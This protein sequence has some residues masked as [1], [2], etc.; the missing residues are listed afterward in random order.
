MKEFRK[1]SEISASDRR[2]RKK[3]GV[4]L[5]CAWIQD[6]DLDP[7]SSV[8]GRTDSKV[9]TEE[10]GGGRSGY[11]GSAARVQPPA[12]NGPIGDIPR[13]GGG[14]LLSARVRATGGS[15]TQAKRSPQLRAVR[16][17]QN[18]QRRLDHQP[19]SFQATEIPCFLFPVPPERRTDTHWS[20]QGSRQR[21]PC[22]D[23]RPDFCRLAR[24]RCTTGERCKSTRNR[25]EVRE[26]R[27]SPSSSGL[28]RACMEL[29]GSLPRSDHLRGASHPSPPVPP[30]S[31]PE[32]SSMRTTRRISRP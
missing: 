25:A 23:C 15:E 10:P 17:T 2:L 14:E 5:N 1:S 31:P 9:P 7:G 26:L 3:R 13:S 22:R 16:T 19:Q 24:S 12:A 30:H 20:T 21:N 27:T 6:S 32:L 8:H 4:K 29:A 28:A 18:R 11:D